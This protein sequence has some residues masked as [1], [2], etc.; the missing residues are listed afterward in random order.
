MKI[1]IC[2]ITREN[3]VE[4]LNE[5]HVDYAGFVLFFEKSK[6]NRSEERR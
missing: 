1:K 6:R 4:L 2:G 3:E 5:L